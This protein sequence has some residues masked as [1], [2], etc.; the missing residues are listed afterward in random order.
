MK[1][2]GKSI[3]TFIGSKNYTISRKF[4]S[5]LGFKE[6]VTSD[7]MSYFYLDRFGFYLQDYYVKDWVENSMIFLEVN[8]LE[9]TLKHIQSLKLT[10]KYKNVRLSEI[11]R[12]EWGNEFFLHDPSGILWHFGI[13]KDR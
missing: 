9:S 6:F 13:F 12:N 1:V 11:V 3:R 8:N 4:Y 2:S 7:K 5:E 10:E